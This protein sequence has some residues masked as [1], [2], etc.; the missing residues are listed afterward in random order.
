MG[1]K[2]ESHDEEFKRKTVERMETENKR[3]IEIAREL[4]IPESTLKRWIIQYGSGAA[5]TQTQVFVDYERLKKL[6]QLNL[7]LQEENEI[8]KKA[9]HFFTKDPR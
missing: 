6:E 7:E 2:R 5:E 3:P 9:R 8:L 4:N 1:N